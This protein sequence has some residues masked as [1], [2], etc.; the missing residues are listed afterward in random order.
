VNPE[1]A[2]HRMVEP[3]VQIAVWAHE[4]ACEILSLQTTA[5][6]IQCVL[7]SAAN[8]AA[9]LDAV[10]SSTLDRARSTRLNTIGSA[11]SPTLKRKA[12]GCGAVINRQ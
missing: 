8:S 2:S 1:S 10:S 6:K 12:P 3:M 5:L 9:Y 4:W 7:A 11:G